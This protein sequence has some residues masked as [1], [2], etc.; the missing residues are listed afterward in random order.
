MHIW[1]K[2]SLYSIEHKMLGSVALLTAMTAVLTTYCLVIKN[3]TA[4]NYTNKP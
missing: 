3:K 4:I 2:I 1:Q